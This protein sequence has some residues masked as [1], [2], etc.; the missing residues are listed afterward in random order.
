MPKTKQKAMKRAFHDG[1]RK[2]L[3]VT[4]NADANTYGLTPMNSK[5]YG[6]KFQQKIMTRKELEAV[7]HKR[8]AKRSVV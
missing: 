3:P 4:K 2:H 6:T 7:E 1:R 5:F 8:E